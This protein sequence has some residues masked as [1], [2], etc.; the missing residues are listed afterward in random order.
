MR[1][2]RETKT[3]FAAL[4]RKSLESEAVGMGKTRN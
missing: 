3:S 2:C 4:Q 1:T